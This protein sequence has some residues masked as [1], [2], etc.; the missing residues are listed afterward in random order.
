MRLTYKI[1]VRKIIKTQFFKRT[2]KAG[3][4]WLKH[5]LRRHPKISGRRWLYSLMVVSFKTTVEKTG[6]DKRTLSDGRTNFV[7]VWRKILFVTLVIDKHCFVLCLLPFVFVFS[8]FVTILCAFFV[9]YSITQIR[10]TCAPNLANMKLFLN[11]IFPHFSFHMVLCL[12]SHC[13]FIDQIK[14]FLCFERFYNIFLGLIA[15]YKRTYP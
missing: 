7:L 5:F 9:Y 13:L 2:E 15:V 3:R 14:V 11:E 6:Y 1:A 10:N 4:K 12:C 8:Y